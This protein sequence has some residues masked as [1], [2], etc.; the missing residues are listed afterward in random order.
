MNIPAPQ[1]GATSQKSQP[2]QII[3]STSPASPDL[4][5]RGLG[6]QGS[7]PN[8]SELDPD[9]GSWES[10]R[11]AGLC[12]DGTL[13]AIR[14]VT[15][16]PRGRRA[17]E[18][19]LERFHPAEGVGARAAARG[20]GLPVGWRR[21]LRPAQRG[22]RRSLPKPVQQDAGLTRA[23]PL[24]CGGSPPPTGGGPRTQDKKRLHRR[25][26]PAGCS[27]KA[28]TGPQ[29]RARR[30]QRLG[31]ELTGSRLV[32]TATASAGGRSRV[33]GEQLLR[34]EG[35]SAEASGPRRLVRARK[36]HVHG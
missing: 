17:R 30:P 11:R 2:L 7:R 15:M 16:A 31:P 12:A 34:A 1:G 18:T 19:R 24:R 32:D 13:R 4:S 22:R 35:S 3:L 21:S 29:D 5:L 28:P 9:S 36:P 20:S 8:I 14:W 25:A 6:L 27:A 10:W 33:L 23:P 26:R